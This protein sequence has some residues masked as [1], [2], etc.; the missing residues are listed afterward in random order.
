MSRWNTCHILDVITGTHRLWQ[1][2]AKGAGQVLDREQTAK[3]GETLS[4]HSSAKSWSSLW[5]KKLN[6]AWLPGENVFL[7]LIELPASTF[8]ETLAMVELQ[9]EKLSPIPVTQ[10]V[11][12]LHVLPRAAAT[13]PAA[14]ALQTVVVVIVE[15]SV[16]EEFLGKLEGHSYQADRLEVPL[17]DQLECADTKTDG[18]WVYPSP[19]AGQNGAL[20]A[21]WLGGVLR[22]LS[23]VTLPPEGSTGEKLQ[24]QFA[25]LTWAGEL[26]GWLT[27][28]PP[29]HLVADAVTAAQ[30]ELALRASMDVPVTVTAPLTS[31][32]LAGR[33]AQRTA[34]AS[35]RANLLPVEFATRYHQQFVDRLWL[36]GL[37]AA[38]VLYAVLVALYFTVVYV[39]FIGVESKTVAVEQQVAGLGGSYTNALQLRARYG[40][41]KEREDLKYA[42]LD[43]WQLIADSLPTGL[44]IQRLSFADGRKLSLSGTVAPE[45]INKIIDFNDSLRKAT[46]NGEPMFDPTQGDPFTERTVGGQVSWN[47]GLVL[48]HGEETLQR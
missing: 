39:P 25:R 43:C 15:R 3:P 37:M 26:E 47:F 45:D 8:D 10:I 24:S 17:L 6:V 35:D 28:R 27:S 16:V 38:G 1:F 34:V 33:T 42:A 30:W 14:P 9:L 48:K 23:L 13:D 46:N 40:V 18:V 22:D 5:R 19:M 36:R 11:W 31:V 32:E 21:W 2:D 41:L 7:K 29:A 12:M 44:A 4:G 20:V